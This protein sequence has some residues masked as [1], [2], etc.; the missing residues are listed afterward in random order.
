MDHTS[1]SGHWSTGRTLPTLHINVKA[2]LNLFTWRSAILCVTNVA[3][4][5]ARVRVRLLPAFLLAQRHQ[6]YCRNHFSHSETNVSTA[7]SNYLMSG[8]YH[9]R[10]A[11]LALPCQATSC[12]ERPSMTQPASVMLGTDGACTRPCHKISC[13]R[14][15]AC[16]QWHSTRSSQTS[17]TAH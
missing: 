3:H 15:S 10:R 12:E 6:S 2:K 4:F 11:V 14:M 16:L 7:A 17:S 9:P 13:A 5:L 1:R 8:T